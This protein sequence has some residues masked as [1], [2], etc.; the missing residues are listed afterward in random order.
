MY[1]VGAFL[2][3]IMITIVNAEKIYPAKVVCACLCWCFFV[4]AFTYG[5]A[6][7][8]QK[9]YTDFRVQ[10]VIEDLNELEIM[11]T[12]E[13]KKIQLSGNI[14]KAPV[15]RNMPQNYQMLNRLVPDTF[16]G[17]WM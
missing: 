16:G 7:A 6:L 3:L 17:G 2:A 15:I 11:N 10:L 13:I 12:E 1:G 14:G 4:F 5:N 9:N 8:A